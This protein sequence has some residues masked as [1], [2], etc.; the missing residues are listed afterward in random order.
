[1]TGRRAVTGAGTVARSGQ[2]VRGCIAT[3][4]GPP[5]DHPDLDPR[6]R[7]RPQGATPAD[8]LHATLD[9]AQA[10]ERLGYTRYWVAEHHNMPGVASSATSVLIGYLAGDTTRSASARAASCCPTTRRW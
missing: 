5:N 9:L 2:P 1:M 3:T 4:P 8:A 7:H 6:S 10:A